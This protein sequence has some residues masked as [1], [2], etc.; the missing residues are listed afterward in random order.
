MLLLSGCSCFDSSKSEIPDKVNLQVGEVF[1]IP[2]GANS[3]TGY[4]WTIKN[5]PA[6]VEFLGYDSALPAGIPLPGS[7]SARTYK[8]KALKSGTT[9]LT[10]IYE[11]SKEHG[12]AQGDVMKTIEIPVT[13]R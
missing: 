5:D 6:M 12:F 2:L 9:M 1:S 13:I 11:R 8:F 7:G 10:L 3:S 4:D